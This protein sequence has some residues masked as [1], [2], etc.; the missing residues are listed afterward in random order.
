MGRIGLAAAGLIRSGT[1]FLCALLVAAV[2]VPVAAFQ[3]LAPDGPSPATG[4]AQVVAQG[5]AA[6]P[7]PE[8]AWRV[9]L[10]TAELPA[11]SAVEERALGFALA[12]RAAIVVDDQATGSQTRLAGGEALFVPGAAQQRRSALGPAETPYYRL[13]LVPAGQATDAGGD[14]LVLA[15]D[16]FAAPPGRAFDLDLVR[17]VLDPGEE[18]LIRGTATPVLVLGT[19]GTVEVRAGSAPAVRLAA[20]QARTFTGDLAVAGEGPRQSAFVAAVIGPE[21]PAPPA[22]PAPP[23]GTITIDVRACPAGLTAAEAAA[24]GFGGDALAPCT[25]QA[26]DPL[27]TLT[28][29]NGQ[30]L[31]PDVTDP[32]A[33]HYTWTGLLYSPFPVAV[34]PLPRPFRD[35][36]L[37][38]PTVGVVAASAGSGVQPTVAN[39]GLLPVGAARPDVTATLYLFAPGEGSVRLRAFACPA[40]T[41]EERFDPAACERVTEG[42][43]A[44]LTRLDDGQPLDLS[45]AVP[46]DEGVPRWTD[47]APG[48]YLLTVNALP[49]GYDRAVVT[50]AEPDAATGG[51]RLSL[52]EATPTATVDL[53]ALPEA[54]QFGSIAV[55]VY[56]CPPGMD[57]ATLAGDFCD[58][59]DPATVALA[60]PDGTPLDPAVIQDNLATWTELPTGSFTIATGGIGDRFID[61]FVP[62]APEV[63]PG[64]FQ[65]AVTAEAPAVET[66]IFR[67]QPADAPLPDA[68]GDGLP[69]GAESQVGTDPNN[70]DTDGD[71][72]ADGDEVG[73]RRVNTDPLNPDTD[74][75]GSDDGDEIAA[76]SDP[77]DP[78]SAP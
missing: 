58:A 51:Y 63:A 46:D 48:D 19:S 75:D 34:P 11:E 3:V 32:A 52:D 13:A 69:D 55:R 68:D 20:G 64:Q 28:L 73:E 2:A 67:F 59:A 15:G 14:R 37:I 17:D 21:V 36:V 41:T 25:A 6:M 70:P 72:R 26:L 60:G 24:A 54:D 18:T 65:L 62:N 50:G 57:R 30:A 78:T 74:G 71:G 27:P 10:D 31:P 8:V 33:G 1:L 40:G 66:A 42:I 7:A 76:G 77:L 56:D 4:H 47:L 29:A 53:F 39:P 38:D 43:A 9:V 35:W 44:T 16:P 45:Q 5:V 12:D 22:P 23:T 49:A 61:A